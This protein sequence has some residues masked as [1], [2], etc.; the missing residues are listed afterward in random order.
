MSLPQLGQMMGLPEAACLKVA[1]RLASQWGQVMV[2]FRL[3]SL[4]S[5]CKGAGRGDLL[6]YR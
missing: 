1:E 5:R 4:G 3:H 6:C 2:I